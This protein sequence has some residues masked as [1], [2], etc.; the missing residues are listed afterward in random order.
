MNKKMLVLFSSMFIIGML[1]IGNGI[2]GLY[3]LDFKQPP[4]DDNVDCQDM[5]VCCMFY[6]ENFGVCD[7]QDKCEGIRQ[8]TFEA[9][10]SYSTYDNLNDEQ[11]AGELNLLSSHVE[12]PSKTK[13]IYSFLV[14]MVLILFALGG[15]SL[16]KI[17]DIH[18][19]RSKFLYRH[20]K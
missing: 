6:E 12:G 8:L 13:A 10:Q 7:R 9:R 19:G 2:T 20:H 11:P 17:R 18:Q 1:F 15:Y 3:F 4:C 16:G 5:E 14:G